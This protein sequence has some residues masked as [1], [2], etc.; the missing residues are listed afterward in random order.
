[1]LNIAGLALPLTLAFPQADL[2]VESDST[3]P[4]VFATIQGAVDPAAP[5]A[6]SHV[7]PGEYGSVA[8]QG[9]PVSIVGLPD[10]L[11][12]FPTLAEVAVVDVSQG[13]VVLQD[14]V[15]GEGVW[16]FENC[17][18][19]VVVERVS[20]RRFEATGV[21]QLVLVDCA[22]SGGTEVTDSGFSGWDLDLRSDSA[23]RPALNSIGSTVY[24]PQSTVAG[25]D[26]GG[27]GGGA[28]G[29]P[30]FGFCSNGGAGGIGMRLENSTASTLQT[31]ITGGQGG[32][33][34]TPSGG[35]P[36]CSPGAS[37]PAVAGTGWTPLPPAADEHRL[38]APAVAQ[39]PQPL[40]LQSVGIPGEAVFRL[41]SSAT[42]PAL[43]LEWRG[44]LLP[45][46][47]SLGFLYA[48]VTPSTGQLDLSYAV[49]VSAG[50]DALFLVAQTAHVDPLLPGSEVL[51]SP[52]QLR[53]VSEATPLI[54]C[55]ANGISDLLDISSDT[56][57]DLNA[58]LRPDDCDQV[59]RIP[60]DVPDLATAVGP[61]VDGGEII[62]APGF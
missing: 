5:G 17:P 9:K 33:A 40:A 11:G 32:P 23:L 27:G 60:A 39:A 43:F 15:P 25:V 21:E 51:G 1:M 54:D 57:L 52:T 62:I 53:L 35:F 28:N 34:W 18:I 50:L 8:L 44:V 36:P 29:G 37:A 3:D 61:L 16:T 14:L 19:S 4:N 58:D 31:S 56:S 12:V 48:G 42:A 59:L 10:E 30:I 20:V 7:R 22:A 38:L 47:T 13:Q 26:G 24:L 55:N 49:G 2:L 6:T 46:V 45:S 41:Y